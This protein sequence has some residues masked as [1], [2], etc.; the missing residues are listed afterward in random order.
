MGQSD[1]ARPA[2]GVWAALA[3]HVETTAAPDGE[4]GDLWRA[5]AQRVDPIGFRP[6]LAADVEVKRF[7]MRGGE[8]V[9]VANPRDLIYFRLDEAEAALLPLMDGTR[10]VGEIV[11]ERL[12]Q[13]GD[14]DVAAATTLTRQLEVG[15]FLTHR[16]VDVDGA[17]QRA[18]RPPRPRDRMTKFVKTLSVEWSGAERMVRWLY[19]HG[20]RAMFSRVGKVVAGLVALGGFV[21][22][23]AVVA[24]HDF[25]LTGQSVGLGFVILL[26]L[27]FLI[28]FIHELGHAALL[29]HYGRRVKAAGFRIYFGTP[30]F[31][32]ESSDAL[33]L[34]RRQRIAQSFAGP[35]FEMVAAGVASIALFAF[36]DA[37]IASVLYRFCVLNYFVLFLNLLPL[38]ELDGYWILSD[39]L[40]MP[41]LRPRSLAFTRSDLW[42]KLWHR[43]RFSRAEVGLGLYGIVGVA[44]TVVS[45]FTAFFFWQT[46]FGDFVSTMWDAG[47][48]GILGLAVLVAFVAGP[49][50]RLVIDA[51]RAI[52][53]RARGMWRQARFRAQR[54]WRV[55]AAELLD[56]QPIFDDLPVEVLNEIAGRVRLRSASAGSTVIRQGERADA[57][58][59]VRSGT[60]EVVE[61]DA[62]TGDEHLLRTVGLG[63][64]FGE[65][66]LAQGAPRNATVRATSPVEL[67]EVDKGTFERLL[68]ER[69]KIPRFAPTLEHMAELRALPPFAHLGPIEL[70]DLARRGEWVNVTPGTEVV[71]QGEV[72]DAFYTVGSGRLEITEDGRFVREVGAGE[73]FGEIAL[74]LDTPRIGTVRATTPARV[75]RLGR[76]GFDGLVAAS[77]RRGRLRTGVPLERTWDH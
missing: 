34:D 38:L 12:R 72:G 71:R 63:E 76:D 31:F 6:E 10:T 75:Y 20:L 26:A 55:E 43:E 65:A 62:E 18:L 60:L 28:I 44:F 1:L 57:Y 70:G 33:M 54:R 67:F 9:I 7:E 4:R 2:E 61:V 48:L 39:W 50:I 69:A 64:A 3:D 52:G 77:F 42:H 40:R 74:L 73:H 68:A 5:L 19:R 35:Y 29:V 49:V 17:V 15:G 16:Y 46:T 11:V 30:A 59:V 24:S 47:M 56:A 25:H 53:R 51:L 66:G 14:L 58:Y 23:A 36:P 37:G 22:F 32:I 41:D 13:G 21:A 27:D 45:L 8:E